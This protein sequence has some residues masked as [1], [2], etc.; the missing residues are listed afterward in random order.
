MFDTAG[1]EYTLPFFAGKAMRVMIWLQDIFLG[2][3]TLS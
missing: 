2:K 1:E 3:S